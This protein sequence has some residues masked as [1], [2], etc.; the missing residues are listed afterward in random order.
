MMDE[1]RSESGSSF[2]VQDL[3]EH[4]LLIKSDEYEAVKREL[5]VEVSAFAVRCMAFI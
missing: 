1:K 4:H 2:I 3:D 5:E